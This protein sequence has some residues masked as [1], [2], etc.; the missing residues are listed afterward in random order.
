MKVVN[1]NLNRYVRSQAQNTL[2]IGTPVSVFN[3]AQRIE[4]NHFN[5]MWKSALA[6]DLE[7]IRTSYNLK[8]T[9]IIPDM[10]K[11]LSLLV[12]QYH[13]HFAI[14]DSHAYIVQSPFK[15]SVLNKIF[16]Y[17]KIKGHSVIVMQ[18]DIARKEILVAKDK[19][20]IFSV[21]TRDVRPLHD[22]VKGHYSLTPLCNYLN[23]KVV[24]R[25][26]FPD[27]DLLIFINRLRSQSFESFEKMISQFWFKEGA[28]FKLSTD[29]PFKK[30]GEFT[31]EELKLFLRH[32][33]KNGE[34]K[35]CKREEPV[36][37]EVQE[38]TKESHKEKFDRML[39]K[40]LSNSPLKKYQSSPNDTLFNLVQDIEEHYSLI[41][42]T[43][44]ENFV[45]DHKQVIL[46]HKDDFEFL[47]KFFPFPLKST[48]DDWE[49][50]CERLSFV[51]QFERD[52]ELK[53]NLS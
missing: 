34:L 22:M 31:R 45:D 25:S 2:G 11:R 6:Q 37:L 28:D 33:R 3:I 7:D 39:A 30:F 44:L 41:M 5:N 27:A 38:N 53:I 51:L 47:K 14:W 16:N 23:E 35:S 4:L 36:L 20:G 42:Q 19:S 50:C 18:S 13:H 48:Y 10:L 40:A 15:K 52:I 24:D 17:K 43:E 9:I 49:R 29:V 32:L 46:E 1:D 12:E 8:T 26:N 21:L